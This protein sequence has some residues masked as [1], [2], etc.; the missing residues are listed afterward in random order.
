LGADAVI[1]NPD[2]KEW[3]SEASKHLV[4]DIDHSSADLFG[5]VV[6]TKDT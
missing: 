6:I 1:N 4:A 5:K 3:S 2:T